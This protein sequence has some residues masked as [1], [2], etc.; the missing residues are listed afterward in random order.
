MNKT[1]LRYLVPV[2]RGGIETTTNGAKYHRVPE[3]KSDEKHFAV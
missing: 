3:I 2:F 1:K